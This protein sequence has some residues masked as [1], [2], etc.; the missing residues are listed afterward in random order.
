MKHKQ[1]RWL[2][3]VLFLVVL[4][5]AISLN[6]FMN[7]NGGNLGTGLVV[8]D[9]NPDV[10]MVIPD[11]DLLNQHGYAT[12][13]QELTERAD[14]KFDIVLSSSPGIPNLVHVGE[15]PEAVVEI[16]GY[17]S[18]NETVEIIST[19]DTLDEDNTEFGH[20]KTAVFAIESIEIEDAV[21]KL[22]KTHHVEYI[23]QCDDFDQNNFE[24]DD[25]AGWQETDTEFIDNGD[26]ITFTVGHF[27][28]YAGGGD[29]E[30][31][32]A[33]LTIWDNMDIGM[34]RGDDEKYQFDTVEFFTNYSM[35][36]GSTIGSETD[37]AGV[38]CIINFT[39]GDSGIMDYIGAYDLYEYDNVFEDAGDY[40]YNVSCDGSLL[41]YVVLNTTDNV[42]ILSL[43]PAPGGADAPT[44]DTLI[45]NATANNSINNLTAY[46]TASDGD[47][48]NITNIT[49]WY[50]NDTSITVLNMP[51]E[52][53]SNISYTKDY[54]T[55][56]N[57][58]ST[59]IAVPVSGDVDSFTE[60]DGTGVAGNGIYNFTITDSADPWF[61]SNVDNFD[62]TLNVIT[63]RYKNY[64]NGP[65]GMTLFYTDNND[66]SGFSGDCMESGIPLDNTDTDWH[67]TT[68]AIQDAEWVDNSGIIDDLRF[69]WD[70][71]TVLDTIQIDY[72]TFSPSADFN[73]TGGYDGN[74]AYEFDGIT[75][76]L[77]LEDPADNSFDFTNAVTMVAWIKPKN[78]TDNAGRIFDKWENGAEDKA[79]QWYE[80]TQRVQLGF[81]FTDFTS[82]SAESSNNS[83]PNNVWTHVAGTYDGSDIKMYVNGVL[84][85]STSV[86][87]T[88]RNAQGKMYIG[89]NPQRT[90]LNRFFNGT[91][92]DVMILDRVLTVQQIKALYENRTDIIVSEETNIGDIWNVSVTPNDGGEDGTTVYST[93]LTVLSNVAPSID[94][95]I[96]NSSNG[97]NYSTE[98]LTAYWTATDGDGDNITNITN[99]YINDT[100][101]TVLNMPFEKVNDTDTNNAWDYSSYLNNGSIIGATWNST[102]GYDGKGAYEFDGNDYIDL[103]NKSN[104]AFGTGDFTWSAWIYP[105]NLSDS[106]EMIFGFGGVSPYLAANTTR[107][108][109]YLSEVYETPAGYLTQDTWQHVAVSR[110]N[111][112]MQ[113]YQNGVAYGSTSTQAG[114]ISQQSGVIGKYGTNDNHYFHGNIDLV[115]IFNRS[116]SDTQIL[117]IY[118]NRTDIIVAEETNIGDVWNVSVTPND[119]NGDGAILYSTALTVLDI[120]VSTPIILSDCGNISGA[121]SYEL[122]QSINSQT[123]CIDIEANNITLDCQGY[124]INYSIGGIL[125]YG[126]NNTGGKDNITIKNCNIVEGNISTNSKYAIYLTT[127]PYNVTIYNNNITTIGSSSMGI[128]TTG[129]KSLNI[130]KNIITT[131]NGSSAEYAIQLQ[132][133]SDNSIIEHNI[134]NSSDMGI[135]ISQSDYLQIINNSINSTDSGGFG[136]IY[137]SDSYRSNLTLNSIE[138]PFSHGI[139]LGL[140]S[141][142]LYHNHSIDTTNTINGYIIYYYFGNQS[143]TISDLTNVGEIILDNTSS[144]TIRNNTFSG[145]GIFIINSTD[146]IIE[147]NNFT[148]G[149]EAI[150]IDGGTSKN[151]NISGNTINITNSAPFAISLNDESNN[152]LIENNI[153]TTNTSS[154][155][156][157]GIGNYNGDSNNNNITNNTITTIGTSYANGIFLASKK[158]RIEQ[159]NITTTGSPAIYFYDRDNIVYNNTIVSTNS[160][161]AG[162]LY[163]D[164]GVTTV[165][166]NTIQNNNISCPECSRCININRASN[167]TIIDNW[168]NSSYGTITLGSSTSGNILTNNVLLGPSGIIWDTST[169]NNTFIY[170]NSHGMINWTLIDFDTNLNLE[171]N[172]TIFLMNNLVGMIDNG[173]VDNLNSSAQIQFYSLGYSSTPELHKDGVR[174]DDGNN[175]NISYDNVTGT[176]IANVSSFSNYTTYF[177]NSEPTITTPT[178]N[179][180][181]VNSTQHLNAS[182]IYQD[183]NGDTGTLY[184]D[185]YVNNSK[186]YSEIVLSVANNTNVSVKL[187]SGNYSDRANITIEV[188]PYDGTTNGTS[189]NSTQ[190]MQICLNPYD[191]LSLSQD[192]ILCQGSYRIGD[193]GDGV[194]QS[195]ANN[196]NITCDGTVLIGTQNNVGFYIDHNFITVSGCTIQK[197]A[198]GLGIYSSGQYVTI[199][200]N[201]FS[202]CVAQGIYITTGDD[203]NITENTFF[204]NTQEGI[205]VSSTGASNNNIWKNKFLGNDN[206]GTKSVS[207]TTNLCV[208]NSY[209]NYYDENVDYEGVLIADCGPSPNATIKLYDKSVNNNWTWGSTGTVTYNNLKEAVYNT[210]TGKTITGMIESGTFYENDTYTI[211]NGITLDCNGIEFDDKANDEVGIYFIAEDSWTIKNCTFN[212]YDEAIIFD[213]SS[214]NNT[215]ENCSIMSSQIQGIRIIGDENNITNNTFFNNSQE[216][217]DVSNSGADNNNIWGNKF[218]G[219]GD[220]NNDG[221]NTVSTTTNFCVNDLYGNYYD[222]NVDTGGLVTNDCGPS[223]NSTINIDLNGTFSLEWAGNV[224]LQSMLSGIYNTHNDSGS[225]ILEVI[226][227][228]GPYEET[229]TTLKNAITIECNNATLLND[230]TGTGLYIQGEDYITVQNCVFDNYNIG[231]DMESGSYNNISNNTF[232]RNDLEGLLID[233]SSEYNLIKHNNFT[234]EDRYGIYMGLSSNP[235]YNNITENTFE[236]CISEAIYHTNNADNTSIWRNNFINNSG[237]SEQVYNNDVSTMFNISDTGNY[238]DDYDTAGEGCNDVGGDGFCDLPQD[239]ITGSGNVNDSFAYVSLINFFVEATPSAN[240]INDCGN[241]SAYGSYE[242]DRN[243]NSTTSCIDIMSDNVTLDCKGYTINYSYGGILGYG[244]NNT[245][246]YNNITIKNCNITEGNTSTDYKHGINFNGGTNSTLENNNIT[247]TG[248][249]AYNIY[250][251]GGSN[252]SII[253]NNTINNTGSF[254][255]GIYLQG[256]VNLNISGNTFFPVMEE[257]VYLYPYDV[258]YGITIDTTNKVGGEPIY[259][260][261]NQSDIAIENLTDIGFLY[262]YECDGFNITNLNMNQLGIILDTVTNSNIKGNNITTSCDR[263]S[264]IDLLG[265]STGNTVYNNTITTT[266]ILGYGIHPYGSDN[267]LSHNIIIADG[268]SAVGI[269]MHGSANISNN[270]IITSQSGEALYLASGSSYVYGNNLTSQSSGTALRIEWSDDNI[271]EENRLNATSTGIRLGSTGV[272]GNIFINNIVTEITGSTKYEITDLDNTKY[273]TLIFNNS[274]GQIKRNSTNLTTQMNLSLSETIFIIFN[275][276]GV[277]DVID[278]LEMINNAEIAMY[279]LPYNEIPILTK[280]GITCDDDT[281][282]TTSYNTETGAFIAE[283][284]SFSNYSTTADLSKE[285][286]TLISDINLT[287]NVNSSGTCYTIGSSD[288]TIDCK[289]Y[290]IN[291]SEISSGH[292]FYTQEGYNNITIKNCNIFGASTVASD[293]VNFNGTVNA[294]LRDSNITSLGAVS[295]GVLLS[296]ARLSTVINNTFNI[297]GTNAFGMTIAASNDSLIEDNVILANESATI[298]VNI[299]GSSNNN[300]IINN[301]IT[302]I[303]LAVIGDDGSAII[304]NK[305]IY[306]NSF[307][308]ITW[309]STD[310]TTSINLTVGDNIFLEDNNIGLIDDNNSKEL[311]NSAEIKFYGLSYSETPELLKDNVR[312]DNTNICNISYNSGTGLL[313]ANVSSFSNYTTHISPNISLTLYPTTSYTN[314]TLNATANYTQFVSGTGTIYFNWYINGSNQFNDIIT[315]ITNQTN[316]TAY[317]NQDNFTRWSNVTIQTTPYDGTTNGT[318]VNS[319]V[320]ISNSPAYVNYTVIYSPN[321]CSDTPIN[322]TSMFNDVDFDQ[323]TIYFDWYVDDTIN[324]SEVITSQNQGINISRNLTEDN[325]T[326]GDVI[327]LQTTIYD[328]IENGTAI[329]SSTITLLNCTPVPPPSTP[330]GSG[331]GNDPV[332]PEPE[333]PEPEEPDPIPEECDSSTS[334]DS[335]SDCTRG[336]TTRTCV[337]V[338]SD[339][340]RSSYDESKRC[341]SSNDDCETGYECE[342]NECALGKWCE[343]SDGGKEIYRKGTITSNYNSAFEAGKEDECYEFSSGIRL[344]EYTCSDTNTPIYNYIDCSDGCENGACLECESEFVCDDW[345]SCE[346]TSSYDRTTRESTT[347]YQQSRTCSDVNSCT[348]DYTDTQACCPSGFIGRAAGVCEQTCTQRENCDWTSCRDGVSYEICLNTDE[349]CQ[350]TREIIDR[351]E[352]N[353]N[354]AEEEEEVISEP[355][356]DTVMS[357][358]SKEVYE[359]SEEHIKELIDNAIEF[360]KQDIFEKEGYHPENL[361]ASIVETKKVIQE[362]TTRTIRKLYQENKNNSRINNYIINI[363]EDTQT[364]QSVSLKYGRIISTIKVVDD[365]TSI[366]RTVNA[367]TFVVKGERDES[368]TIANLKAIEYAPKEIIQTEDNILYLGQSGKIIDSSDNYLIEW[369]TDVLN[370]YEQKEISYML[371]EMDDIIGLAF[372]VT[373]K[374]TN[375]LDKNVMP[376]TRVSYSENNLPVSTISTSLDNINKELEEEEEV[377]IS[378]FSMKCSQD[379]L[380]MTLNIPEEY[381]DIRI[382][383]CRDGDCSGIKNKVI[384]DLDC[385]NEIVKEKTIDKEYDN[386]ISINAKEVEINVDEFK[387]AIT[388]MSTDILYLG[389]ETKKELG[390]ELNENALQPNNP[391]L[392]I[393]GSPIKIKIENIEKSLEIRLPYI[394]PKG[395]E[396]ESIGIYINKGTNKNNKVEWEYLGGKINKVDKIITLD[397]EQINDFIEYKEGNFIDQLIN[398]EEES[399]ELALMGMLC[400]NCLRAEL[401]VAYKPKIDQGI[402]RDAIILV[403]G[404]ASSP[405]T[406]ENIINDIKMTE[407]PFQ[408]WTF[409]YPTTESIEENSK[410]FAKLL[411][412]RNN[413]YDR[414]FIAAHSLGG[415]ITQQALHYAY[416]ENIKSPG[417]FNFIEKVKRVV[418]IGTPNEGTPIGPYKGLFQRAINLKVEDELFNVESNIIDEV[419]N[420]LITERVP[421]IEYY[422]IAGDKPYSFSNIFFEKEDGRD[423]FIEPNDGIVSVKSAQNIGGEYVNNSCV[424]FWK[425]SLTHTELLKDSVGRRVIEKI[426]SEDVADDEKIKSVLGKSTFYQFHISGCSEED[427]YI[428]V[429]KKIDERE[430]YDPTGCK[431]GDGYCASFENY[432]NC[433]QDCPEVRKASVIGK[434]VILGIGLVALISILFLVGAAGY[435]PYRVYKNIK[436]SKIKDMQFEMAK[437]MRL[438]KKIKIATKELGS[439]KVKQQLVSKG[440]NIK[441][442]EEYINKYEHK[443]TDELKLLSNKLLSKGM[444]PL[445]ARELLMK[446]GWHKSHVDKALGI[447]PLYLINTMQNY[448]KARL[449]KGHDRMIIREDLVKKGW[450][451]NHVDKILGITATDII[452]HT[453]PYINKRLKKGHKKSDIR[454]DLIKKGWDH[455]YVDK[456]LEVTPA[457]AVAELGEYIKNR[458]KKGHKH[459]HIREDLLKAGWPQRIVDRY[460]GI[461]NIEGAKILQQHIRKEI[462][463]KKYLDE[464]EKSL[465]KKGWN[466]LLVEKIINNEKILKIKE[467]KKFVKE[468][469][470]RGK[471]VLKIKEELLEKDWN[472]KTIDKLFSMSHGAGLTIVIEYIN[473]LKLKGKDQYQI[474]EILT[475]KGWDQES[476]D[477]V[478]HIGK[479]EGI[480]HSLNYIKKHLKRGVHPHDIRNALIKKGWDKNVVDKIMNIGDKAGIMM[481]KDYMHYAHKHKHDINQV[482]KELLKLGWSKDII[483]RV[484]THMNQEQYEKK[485]KSLIDYTVAHLENNENHKQIEKALVKKGWNKEVAHKIISLG[486]T[487]FEK[488]KLKELSRYIKDLLKKGHSHKQITKHL[489]NKGWSIK[490]I[491]RVIG[492]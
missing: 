272:E 446:K 337:S 141:T 106:Y 249:Y 59:G 200:N 396:N 120:P 491:K 196:V 171:I 359:I 70:G 216:G 479:K 212:N 88:I 199:K 54:S 215:V 329:N 39:N 156:G 179:T 234:T 217:V 64:V 287:Q 417:T 83:V 256:S 159:N 241:I 370:P 338:S 463:N 436:I 145:D 447:T 395:F 400:L 467:I 448:I 284:S 288:I 52:G 40:D 434:S 431:C 283:V 184:F 369:K 128:R 290:T 5:S 422:V 466:R 100:S 310:I 31:N 230:G 361:N 137:L 107:L 393:I 29:N 51:F 94:T 476:I 206:D 492:K 129:S 301:N 191:D 304:N 185:W 86:S 23:L 489:L 158:N 115:Q 192:T 75:N 118:E 280:N 348:S 326:I 269:L 397:I 328:G 152:N 204:N 315:T 242:L 32:S 90:S 181:S 410:E 98:N 7:L 266:G 71:D 345:S 440:W 271:I 80:A 248:N 257:P 160:D 34:Y 312:C 58:F 35:E 229:L 302:I 347:S 373:G 235:Q 78:N 233:V 121:G 55:Y 222:E 374:Y 154:T 38:T 18:Y 250:L 223:P 292:G 251:N 255:K 111:G 157:I 56:G 343:D 246:G 381:G 323:G 316:T 402:V 282:N 306:N 24:C 69:D 112:T 477:N 297:S 296:Y 322:G 462:K 426:V 275:K 259:F 146:T 91:I 391:R 461:N 113:L 486:N 367:V 372:I 30:T 4:L 482:N 368:K 153:I 63:I 451:Y 352:C 321:N 245:D 173:D 406:Y 444:K 46:W 472:K 214:G 360:T 433:Q 263:N 341:C 161:N 320:N 221:V 399:V 279:G 289:G 170:N 211:R 333:D 16:N 174:C 319:S 50:L 450:H 232:T 443:T 103:G 79:F 150:R 131:K 6:I 471:S 277:L 354:F 318:S 116:L 36:N 44:V 278:A 414:I 239:N 42:T 89:G 77:N 27:S 9:N 92:D 353:V 339:C 293:G 226:A 109:F 143:D 61:S 383:R 474:R 253:I 488:N 268:N 147:R 67:I 198:N 66:C 380:D 84:D 76:N 236:D 485:V 244:I 270:S 183:D 260:Y 303:S 335:W 387:Q 62:E 286:G 449:N 65:N 418:A 407:Q 273:N 119:G 186:V 438:E 195:G 267:N 409:S 182:T 487:K 428:V 274:F 484:I 73:A 294:T 331:G 291:Y 14:N 350:I 403:H 308:E 371:E 240:I 405:A 96:L 132:S 11:V 298:G 423:I 220:S 53:G 169:G 342:N 227:G 41:G 149:S 194:I 355:I 317:F 309:T 19:I 430:V 166:N 127:S 168:V 8:Y 210:E 276:T 114:S 366:S 136:V 401:E 17:D 81:Y 415:M 224:T 10:D 455:K 102:A 382:L 130:S 478:L 412:S 459:I 398:T 261:F 218:L 189:V 299:Q 480:Q 104:F 47:G 85:G 105:T 394:V 48:D 351:E 453:K 49:N 225:A 460:L 458:V 213:G 190:F 124:T 151:N 358:E 307:G 139:T 420:G 201:S 421:E 379:N 138:A 281:C 465:V 12:G 377:V 356:E 208:N 375:K 411:E 57:H 357:L 365:N 416:K 452:S 425:L 392:K 439:E 385:G 252:D 188:T 346:E 384:D 209:G 15:L 314:D 162:S 264:G 481:L 155:D 203:N 464:V 167:N 142:T 207:T 219:N 334:C 490:S 123:T 305:L 483:K 378:P 473:E 254:S 175:C 340:T 265:T 349:F 231:I 404:L 25:A 386:L 93:G 2:T 429:G 457:D 134:I 87:K 172:E 45:L 258:D 13:H 470:L 28:G 126:I 110:T 163:L 72:I 388:G 237:G 176:L 311:N 362:H 327:K 164:I 295:R 178:F 454:N 20:I 3:Q 135:F 165:V 468:E 177:D 363:K 427:K 437:K 117:S 475:K 243:I 364:G 330:I 376:C 389:D 324:F 424:D 313:T 228:S 408:A 37:G 247:T 60:N 74:G 238:W 205:D 95:L 435:T 300:T 285:C 419:S 43:G 332:D 133:G 197:Y 101:I 21:I 187:D 390:I 413:E 202:S 26:T 441:V 97:N 1:L 456:L 148:I 82:S 33:N 325:F 68:H 262:L 144:M 122:N 99:W 469:L 193:G 180:T 22:P 432:N 336:E 125:G 140:G 108:H 344:I 445:K 442:I